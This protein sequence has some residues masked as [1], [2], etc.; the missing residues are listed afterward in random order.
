[1]LDGRGSEGAGGGVTGIDCLRGEARV[2]AGGGGA[3]GEL[4][5]FPKAF[6]AACIATD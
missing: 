2:E 5:P 1:M 6:R 3:T 4:D